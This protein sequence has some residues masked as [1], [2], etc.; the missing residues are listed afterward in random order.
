MNDG[1]TE[2]DE[3][4]QDDNDTEQKV[5]W[6][7]KYCLMIRNRAGSPLSMANVHMGESKGKMC[8]SPSQFRTRC[9]LEERGGKKEGRRREGGKEKEEVG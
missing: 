7:K 6:Q 8:K 1:E 9:R 5:E 2:D 4:N 3:D